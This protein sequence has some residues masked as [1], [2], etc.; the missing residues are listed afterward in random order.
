[1]RGSTNLRRL[2]ELEAQDGVDGP[3]GRVGRAAEP[4][5]VA[6]VLVEPLGCGVAVDE[7]GGLALI[8]VGAHRVGG[9]ED[10][11][12]AAEAV[13]LDLVRV[14]VRARVTV[15][16]RLRVRVRVG[17]ARFGGGA[18]LVAVIERSRA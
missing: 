18:A 14:R 2:G 5:R 1:M 4:A 3:G 10:G 9:G 7:V 17:K 13:E 16:V 12:L 6:Q 11:D 8:G 15:R